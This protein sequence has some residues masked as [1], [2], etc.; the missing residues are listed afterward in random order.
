MPFYWEDISTPFPDIGAAK[1]T[2]LRFEKTF[3]FADGE[4]AADFKGSK[5]RFVAAN[6]RDELYLLPLNV[7]L[8]RA[9]L[10]CKV[11]HSTDEETWLQQLRLPRDLHHSRLRRLFVGMQGQGRRA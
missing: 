11:L 8:Y 1:L 5:R 9:F 10:F 2:R 3:V 4:A 7:H 6:N